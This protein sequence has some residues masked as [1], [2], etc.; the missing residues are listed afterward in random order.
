MLTLTLAGVALLSGACASDG[1]EAPATTTTTAPPPPLI[2]SPEGTYEVNWSALGAPPYFGYDDTTDPEDPFWL[3]NNQTQVDGFSFGLEMY[4]TGFGERWQGRLGK[5]RIWCD[6]RG[7]GICLHFDPDGEGPQP[8]L[9]ADF[10]TTGTVTIHELDPDG[11]HL[12][13]EDVEFTDGSRI[14]GPLELEG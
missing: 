10:A 14:P 7:T 11:Y 6:R 12:V 13:L 9:G 1:E 4:T 2:E 8:D 3:I 5:Y